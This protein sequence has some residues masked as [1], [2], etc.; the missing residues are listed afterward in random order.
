MGWG[1][2]ARARLE[3]LG[4]IPLQPRNARTKA[5]GSLEKSLK[6]MVLMESI[7]MAQRLDR[8]LEPH[9]VH[10]LGILHALFAQAAPQAAF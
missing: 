8:A 2:A 3:S 5:G 9:L 6:P 4:V 7:G 1:S 10:P